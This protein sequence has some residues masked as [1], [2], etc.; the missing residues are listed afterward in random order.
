MVVGVVEY[1]SFVCSLLAGVLY[2][3]YEAYLL[4]SKRVA[5][6]RAAQAQRPLLPDDAWAVVRPGDS[7]LVMLKMDDMTKDE[8]K[9]MMDA[10]IKAA[11]INQQRGMDMV[12]VPVWGPGNI[13]VVN[14]QPSSPPQ[15][16]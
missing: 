5:L 13:I 6:D 15:Q 10:C 2:I 14:Q 9:R 12:V 7:V 8:Q 3:I 4:R 11:K 1:V 16:L